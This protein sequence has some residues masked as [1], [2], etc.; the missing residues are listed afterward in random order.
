LVEIRLKERS[1][2]NRG[3]AEDLINWAPGW[4]HKAILMNG[5]TGGKF[6]ET[7]NDGLPLTALSRE[8]YTSPEWFQRDIERVFRRRWLFVCHGSEVKAAGDYT[9]FELGDDSIVVA[10]DQHGQINA[11][12]NVCRHRGT[13]FCDPG[14]GHVKAFVCPFH[15]WTYNLDGTL[16]GAPHMPGLDKTQYG[17]KRVWCEV[18]NGM[19][20]INFMNEKPTP[21]AAYLRGADLESHRLDHAKVI[22][23]RDYPTDANWKIN[24]ET[25]QECYHCAVVHGA[26]L[27]RLLTDVTN[28]T[29]YS[30]VADPSQDAEYMIYSADM[31]GGSLKPGVET[32]TWDGKLASKRLLGDGPEPQPPRLLSW[33]PSFSVGAFPD[34]AFIIDWVPVSATRT[35]FRTRWLV[36]EEAVEGV[37]YEREDILRM[38]DTFNLEDK[39]IVNRAQAGVN[40]SAYVGG[41]YQRPF[42]DDTRKY[43]RQYLS[44]V[45]D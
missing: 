23:A 18:W 22:E 41:P 26:S 45:K 38:A 16:R 36:H 42:E 4:Q 8:F 37:D 34:Y 39:L 10:R 24:G 27:G 17:A 6:P 14:C 33:F 31:R 12:H 25:Y 21:V 5:K 40:S 1:S 44:L 3:I 29:A 32:Q 13:R 7:G 2:G 19:V 35:N 28:H 20:F 9:T 30:N 43:I 15:T 11:F